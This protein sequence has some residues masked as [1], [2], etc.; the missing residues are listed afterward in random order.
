MSNLDQDF[1]C[2]MLGNVRRAARA[3]SRRYDRIARQLDLTGAQFSVIALIQG[4]PGKTAGELSEMTFIERTALVRNLA[5]LEKREIVVGKTAAGSVRKEYSLTDAGEALYE[6]A[7]PMWAQA[8]RD[9]AEV[10][11]E[12]DFLQTIE[13]LKRLSKV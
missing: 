3:V 7:V 11:G 2:C 10:L 5:L 9:L 13:K 6:A 4:H 1:D 8:Q 12:E